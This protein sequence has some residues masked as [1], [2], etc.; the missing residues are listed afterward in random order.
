MRVFKKVLACALAVML[1]LPSVSASAEEPGN[2]KASVSVLETEALG[3]VDED[4]TE[5]EKAEEIADADVTKEETTEETEDADVTEET[6]DAETAETEVTEETAAEETAETDVTE[7]TTAE[8]TTETE[9]AADTAVP[10]EE[11]QPDVD[12]VLFNT[13]N[14]AYSVVNKEAFD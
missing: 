12:E 11:G 8:E 9:E 5:D 1:V 6:E 7:E 2:E 10:E 14:H 4:V 13:G 3:T